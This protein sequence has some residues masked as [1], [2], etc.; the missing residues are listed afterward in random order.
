MKP[1]NKKDLPV[2]KIRR[3]LE[4]GP[5]VLVSSTLR[6]KTNIMTMGWHMVMAVRAF[7][8]WLLHL[9]REPQFRGA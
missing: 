9:E 6:G 3:L 4:P 5:I 8:H 1:F 7:S 2:S